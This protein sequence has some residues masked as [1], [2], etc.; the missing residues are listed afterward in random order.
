VPIN[1]QKHWAYFLEKIFYTIFSHITTLETWHLNLNVVCKERNL[2]LFSTWCLYTSISPQGVF[3]VQYLMTDIIEAKTC[4]TTSQL[5][6]MISFLNFRR[7]ISTV[8]LNKD[9][10]EVK[11]KHIFSL[12]Q[13]IFSSSQLHVLTIYSY[14]QAGQKT[15]NKYTGTFRTET[16]MLYKCTVSNILISRWIALGQR[17]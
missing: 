10:Y 14:C 4:C 1:R 6:I 5:T 16:S 3:K 13:H 8:F 2:I 7:F 15:Q 9:I 12:Y 11:H 17:W